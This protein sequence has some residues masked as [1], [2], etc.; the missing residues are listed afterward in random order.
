[1]FH[2][3]DGVRVL[4]APITERSKDVR[5]AETRDAIMPWVFIFIL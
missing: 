1:M 4:N 3:A 5:T 2:G